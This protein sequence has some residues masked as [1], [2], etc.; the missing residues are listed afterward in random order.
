MRES[1]RR[2]F[3]FVIA[4]NR[5]RVGVMNVWGTWGLQG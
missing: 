1:K 2:T 3:T 4:Y 5:T